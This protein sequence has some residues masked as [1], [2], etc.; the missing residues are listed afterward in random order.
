MGQLSLQSE[1]FGHTGDAI[2]HKPAPVGCRSEWPSWNP[3][4]V[5]GMLTCGRSVPWAA[6]K[7]ATVY[8]ELL[9]EATQLKVRR[10][11]GSQHGYQQDIW[12]T[13]I[14]QEISHSQWLYLVLT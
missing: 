11:H 7:A 14:S 8:W 10:L 9:P 1:N 12:R 6:G 13:Y 4:L 5:W 2:S 3:A